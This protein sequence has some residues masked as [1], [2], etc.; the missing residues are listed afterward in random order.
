MVLV[1]WLDTSSNSNWATKEEAKPKVLT[2]RTIGF[3]LERNKKHIAIYATD[4]ESG[5]ISDRVCIPKGCI[6]S[7]KRLKT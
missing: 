5:N 3:L 4:S 6:K 2:C 7:V 1:E